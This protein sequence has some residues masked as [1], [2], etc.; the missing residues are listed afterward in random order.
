MQWRA[1]QMSSLVS[2]E[3]WKWI[4][5]RMFSCRHDHMNQ[6]ESNP[7]LGNEPV[8]RRLTKHSAASSMMPSWKR[9][10]SWKVLAR[11]LRRASDGRTFSLLY[12]NW[13]K[14]L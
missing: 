8:V 1:V 7:L 11:A 13:A 4:L 2:S 12:W 5:I 6:S 14:M 10:S 9:C 3:M